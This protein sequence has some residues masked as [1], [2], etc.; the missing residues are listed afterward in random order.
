VSNPLPSL[1]PRK[2]EIKERIIAKRIKYC[3]LIAILVEI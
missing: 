2:I 3:D 1:V